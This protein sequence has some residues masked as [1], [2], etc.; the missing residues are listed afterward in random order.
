MVIG[1]IFEDTSLADR[2]EPLARLLMTKNDRVAKLVF[3]S[4]Q[5]CLLQYQTMMARSFKS[6]QI[7]QFSYFDERSNELKE[8]QVIL[9]DV[10]PHLLHHL[11]LTT[12][13]KHRERA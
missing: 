1:E 13:P 2:L 9:V 5:R 8:N 10:I 6:D 11:L 12:I 4:V 7:V 3:K